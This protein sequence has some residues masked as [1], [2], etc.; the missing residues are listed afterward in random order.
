MAA[1]S[2]HIA[3]NA[4]TTDDALTNI[5]TMLTN[6]LSSIQMVHNTTHQATIAQLTQ[7]AQQQEA[8]QLA[9]HATEARIAALMHGQPPVPGI[10]PGSAP[11]SSPLDSFHH[12]AL[13]LC[14]LADHNNVTHA[15]II[16][17]TPGNM[18]T[19]TIRDKDN[20]LGQT[21]SPFHH[22]TPKMCQTHKNATL[23]TITASRVDTTS[24]A[25]TPVQ[26]ATTA[27]EAIKLDATEKM[28][29]STKPWGTSVRALANTKQSCLQTPPQSNSSDG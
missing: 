27:N 18:H 29:R 6:K 20:Q 8:L 21:A 17:P 25:G 5:K 7:L 4:I 24:H 3:A 10:P 13:L 9:L 2:Y 26:L 28:W 14:I 19:T 16:A 1:N 23:T 11:T 12:P 15:T 22:C